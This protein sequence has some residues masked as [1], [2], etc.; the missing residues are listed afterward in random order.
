MHSTGCTVTAFACA[1]LVLGCSGV[2]HC[3]GPAPL[4]ESP[5]GLLCSSVCNV[6]SS[7]RVEIM[8]AHVHMYS[9]QCTHVH[10]CTNVHVQGFVHQNLESRQRFGDYLSL[11]R[12]Q[13]SD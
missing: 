4:R 1:V 3:I 5:P 13:F 8:H 6:Q 7:W 10:V 9:V 12:S 11:C 2:V